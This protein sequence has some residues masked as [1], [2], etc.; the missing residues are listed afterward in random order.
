[1]NRQN[2][3]VLLVLLLAVAPSGGQQGALKYTTGWLGNSFGG[4]PKW[5][6]NFNEQ[7]VV[8]PD[9]TVYLPSFWDEAGREV[10]I[11][12][13][14]NVV[15]K[16]DGTHMRAGF[17]LAVGGGYAYYT[18]TAAREDAKEVKAGEAA[19]EKS[20]CY[21]GVSRYTLDGRAAPFEGGKTPLKNMLS[22][23]EAPDNHD[24]IPQAAVTDGKLLYVADTAQNRVVVIDTAEMKIVRDISVPRPNRLALSP[25]GELWLLSGGGFGAEHY[26]YDA[27]AAEI[28]RVRTGGRIEE[29]AL[30]LPTGSKPSSL[31]FVSEHQLLIADRGP[32]CQAYVVDIS[33]H[34]R[35]VESIGVKG[36][37]YASPNPGA[38]AP[39]RFP[40]LTGAGF[41]AKGRL[42]ISAFPPRGGTVL[43]AFE[44]QRTGWKMLWE[45]YNT[46]FV[47]VPDADPASDGSVAYTA[48]GKYI[49][50]VDG[51][52]RWS[53]QT[54]DPFRYP[55][56]MRQHVPALQC[57]TQV[58]RLEGRT[59]IALR[60]MWQGVLGIYRMDGDTCVPVAAL[61]SG[62][63]KGERSGWKPAGQPENGRF[64]W[65]DTDG[66]GRMD[67]GEYT[68][69]TG[70]SGEYWA[71]NMDTHGDLW[72]AG[73]DTGIWR[74]RFEGLDRKGIPKYASA[75]HHEPMPAP[76]TDLLRTDYQPETD[77]MY[78]T[79][80]TKDREITGGEW[81]TAGT[82][83]C[84]Y[85]DWSKPTRR[86]RYRT[87]LPYEA[88]KTFMASFAV[89]G[90][91]FAVV[92][93]KSAWVF[94]YDNRNG[95]PIGCL[96]PGAEV[97]QESGWIDFCDA[98]RLTRLRSGD[99]EI[100]AEEDFKGKCLVYRLADPLTHAGHAQ[101][102]S[103]SKDAAVKCQQREERANAP[104]KFK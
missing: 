39:L 86:L 79:G 70:P 3:F 62:P 17:G 32:N 52:W 6:Q 82:V 69:T 21:F 66:N 104:D 23:R 28:F 42:Y 91:L 47:D 19:S 74:W 65:R 90:D 50:G 15:G 14:G 94:V 12:R 34:P 68:A 67:V 78:L 97:H 5:V 57:A 53:A 84:R 85:D 87:D 44:R 93:C 99:Y 49:R 38:V 27:P 55:D 61:C 63:V 36:G 64:L 8:M 98:L 72:Q 7:M 81:G 73:R 43:R 48:D 58:R 2:L 10:G 46:E 16:L 24:L 80:Q 45:L 41:D 59:F 30:P 95:K 31:N 88:G 33:T 40:P 96:K 18:H 103:G 100:F 4:G 60:G 51:L 54:L 9:G 20:M 101:R 83:V 13:D 77:V 26:R 29:A 102:T 75:P 71:S 22:F 56:D 35:L 1:M 89:A 37:M 11:Y 76:F 92:D 25:T